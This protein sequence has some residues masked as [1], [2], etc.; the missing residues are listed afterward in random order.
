M[1]TLDYLEFPS[2]ALKA[3]VE[4]YGRAFGWEFKSYGPEYAAHEDG[5][6][7]V[8]LDASEGRV[9][10]ILP[11]IRVDSLEDARAAVLRAGGTIKVEPF[12]YPGGSRFHFV[13]PEGREL[14]C[15][16]PDEPSP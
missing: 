2:G 7:Q 11:V 14:A 10:A 4:F 5:P 12:A 1:A 6:C 16:R 8:G 15:Y 13:D 9:E 3:T